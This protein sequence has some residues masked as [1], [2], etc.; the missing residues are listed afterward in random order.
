MLAEIISIGDEIVSGQRLDTNSQWL[1]RELGHLGIQTRYHTT[2][3]DNLS[4]NIEVLRTAA[5]RADWVICSGGL[6]PTLDDLTRQAISEAF[7]RPLE[8]DSRVLEHI[9]GLF[10]RRSREM[11]ERN[12]VQAMFPRGTIVIPNPHGSAPGIDLRVPVGNRE[13]RIIALP[14]VPA[15]MKDMWYRTVTTRLES[16]LD[17]SCGRL[18][19]QEVKLFGI[20]ESDVEAR[21]PTLIARD[22]NP[23]VGITVS[24]AT[25]TLRIAARAS[26][27]S[28]F[29]KSIAPTLSEIRDELGGLVFAEGP[30]ELQD[31]VLNLLQQRRQ[32]LATLELG[33]ASWLGNWLLHANHQDETCVGCLA[34]GTLNRARDYWLTSSDPNSTEEETYCCLASEL[35]Q[36]TKASMALVIG[37]YPHEAELKNV[38]SGSFDFQFAI[39]DSASAH[40][41]TRK[42]GGA[43]D[44]LGPRVA[45]TGLDFL[46]HYL[47]G[48]AQQ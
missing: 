3:G 46:R 28:D 43:P 47:L 5:E 23:T 1:S 21:L 2:V 7:A 31:V 10:A 37:I 38:T 34:F 15:E 13:S 48:I 32:T 9:R 16:T 40:F 24:Q 45:K 35:R 12:I 36:R 8:L 27:E 19:F 26:S 29:Q 20:G 33:A 30:L 39:A 18:F 41:E 25:I 6:G 42:M 11:P 44:V 14:G 4:A 22:R 17:Q